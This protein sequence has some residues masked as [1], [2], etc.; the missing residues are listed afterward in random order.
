MSLRLHQL[1]RPSDILCLVPGQSD[2]H[3]DNDGGSGGSNFR[4]SV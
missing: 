3:D 4:D 1:T 2:V